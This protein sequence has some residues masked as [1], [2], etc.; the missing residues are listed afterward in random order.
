MSPPDATFDKEWRKQYLR[1]YMR[2]YMRKRRG[3]MKKPKKFATALEA[4]EQHGGYTKAQ[5]CELQ[6]ALGALLA[7]VDQYPAIF[8]GL[9]EHARAIDRRRRTMTY[10]EFLTFA[11]DLFEA[12]KAVA[13]DA[14]RDDRFPERACDRCG[15]LYRGPAVYCSLTCALADA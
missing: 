13:P 9:Y 4:I 15:K 8:A 1:E 7:D 14:Y 10:T 6:S 5:A 11:R 3:N 2:E 12:S